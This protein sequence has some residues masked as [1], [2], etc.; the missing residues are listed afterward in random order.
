MS[1]RALFIIFI[2]IWSEPAWSSFEIQ[3]KDT[4]NL[5][6]KGYDGLT[7]TT[8][9]LGELVAGV[10]HNVAKN[11]KGL[12]LLTFDQGQVYPIVTGTQDFLINITSPNT[13]PS[14]TGSAEN[15]YL[16]A[17][18]K[19][20]EP[21]NDKYEFPELMIQAKQLLDST[22][23]IRSIEE[24][25]AMKEQFHT[26]VR[27]HSQDLYHS[28]MLR[29]LIAQYFMMHEY[30][31]YHVPGTP[32]TS[33]KTRYQDAV[34]DGVGNWLTILKDGIPQHE[35]LNYC[36]SLYYN[37]SMVS[38]ASLIIS[39][40]PESAYCPGE[41]MD[42]FIFSDDLK[43][44]NGNSG[45]SIPLSSIKGD[46]IITLVADDCPVSMAETVTMA[47]RLKA[48]KSNTTMIVA[49]V[50]ELSDKYLSMNRMINRGNLLFVNDENLH[51]N[52]NKPVKLPFFRQVRG[53]EH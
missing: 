24:L 41:M 11:Y 53:V 8:L 45:I 4:V 28:D 35:I 44:I 18:L 43:V 5:E 13:L 26:F 36:V 14:F 42:S 37:R 27:A 31:D 25:R 6:I 20:V 15:E 32:A 50:G 29:R 23:S 48:E 52:L 34:M 17:R 40:F 46:K 7:E 38:L 19:G 21:E 47:R 49:P 12:A 3:S 10:Q 9:F 22:G 39:K 51:K 1:L 30:V 2:L 33:I 16:Y